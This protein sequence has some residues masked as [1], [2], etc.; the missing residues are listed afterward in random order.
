MTKTCPDCNATVLSTSQPMVTDDMVETAWAAIVGGDIAKTCFNASIIRADL[1]MGLVAALAAAPAV[2]VLS[3][4]N[5]SFWLKRAKSCQCCDASIDGLIS[6]A[7]EI[8][9]AKQS[10]AIAAAPD[11]EAL[12]TTLTAMRGSVLSLRKAFSHIED[13]K[14][15]C[16]TFLLKLAAQPAS[17]LR[18]A[19]ERVCW[20]DWSDNDMDAVA[21]IEALRKAV[22]S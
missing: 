9:E 21:A 17:S 22:R 13:I 4:R 19:A 11:G 8:I 20:F 7:I 15:W 18:E 16:D 5:I 6:A 3:A 12:D 1:K 2:G 14:W 10:A